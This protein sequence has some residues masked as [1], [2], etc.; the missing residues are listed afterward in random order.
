MFAYY[1]KWIPEFSEKICP[2]I[3]NNVFPLPENVEIE[4]AI[5]ITIDETIPFKVETDTSDFAIATTLNQVGRPVAF[6]QDL[7]LKK[8]I[9]T[10]QL[11]KHML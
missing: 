10:L 6:F 2:L 7:F 9:D 1:S 3:L 4:N 11:K 5:I 8:N